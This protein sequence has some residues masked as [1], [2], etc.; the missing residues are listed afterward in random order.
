MST[1]PKKLRKLLLRH[2]QDIDAVAEELNAQRSEAE[3]T[4]IPLPH[5]QLLPEFVKDFTTGDTI[6]IATK[7][8][9]DALYGGHYDQLPINV[10]AVPACKVKKQPDGEATRDINGDKD[11][12]KKKKRRFRDYDARETRWTVAEHAKHALPG[13]GLLVYKDGTSVLVHD[14]LGSE[15]TEL[16][17]GPSATI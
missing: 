2:E 8:D 14:F 6:V 17:V 10:P 12:K 11:K 3:S 4:A 16:I 1:L 9:L 7:N 13:R 15:R 5:K